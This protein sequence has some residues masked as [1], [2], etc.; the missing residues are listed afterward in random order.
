MAAAERVFSD[1]QYSLASCRLQGMDDHHARSIS[2]E[3]ACMDPWMRLGYTEES[4]FAYLIRPDPSL[5]R[6]AVNVRG[7]TAGVVCVRYPWLRGPYLELLSVFQ[8]HQGRGIGREIIA[9][10]ADVCLGHSNSI[11]TTVSEFNVSAQAFY[12]NLGFV[13]VAALPDLV[14]GDYCEILLRKILPAIDYYEIHAIAY[15]NKTFAADPSVFLLPFVQHLPPQPRI[16]DIGCGSGRDLLW[17]KQRG[18]ETTGFERSASLAKL[19]GNHSGC[20]VIVGDLE[21]F[22]FSMGSW[23]AVMMIGS[24]VHIPHERFITQIHKIFSCFSSPCV[25][26]LTLKEGDG[27]NHCADGRMFYLWDD[28]TLREIFSGLGLDVISFFRNASAIGSNE[29][30]LGYVLHK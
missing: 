29:S 24:L 19:A 28:A 1:N 27:T 12:R 9:W 2:Q 15:H 18:F 8:S 4:L 11:W 6:Y 3:L 26:L 21:K 5:N 7:E 17:L 16:L 30:W 10:M 13:Q 22:D 25:M 14:S 20:P 23:N